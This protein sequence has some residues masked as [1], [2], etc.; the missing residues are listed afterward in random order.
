MRGVRQHVCDR[1]AAGD[2]GEGRPKLPAWAA[3]GIPGDTDLERYG[4]LRPK[5]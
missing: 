2:W 1:V 4:E 3:H 5:I